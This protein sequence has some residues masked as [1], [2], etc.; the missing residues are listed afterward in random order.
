MPST[1]SHDLNNQALLYRYE[2]KANSETEEET[3]FFF[4]GFKGL[5][6]MEQNGN[7]N[8]SAGTLCRMG[9]GFYGTAALDGMCSKCYKDAIKRK[10]NS[11]PVSGRISPTGEADKVGNV[12]ASL[13]QT[14]LGPS[15]QETSTSNIV[16]GAT[17]VD[18]SVPP[19]I[20]TATTTV[21]VPTSS[22]DKTVD[23]NEEG[24]AG[25]DD[26]QSPEVNKKPKKNRCQTCRKKVGLTGFRCR[27]EGLYCSLHR[28]SDKHSC[29]FDYK[30]MAQEQI[31]KNN[32][33][34]VGE[35]IQKI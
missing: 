9:C 6:D 7:Q 31:R 5:L 4:K 15:N 23:K 33:V 35:K 22:Q 20:K 29:T 32:P 21:P 17:G 10:Q 34:V 25:G 16:E 1:T 19:S 27:C 8:L 30:E 24:A 3:I 13:A 14:S 11:S 26:A 2:R 28:Y 18:T 12:T